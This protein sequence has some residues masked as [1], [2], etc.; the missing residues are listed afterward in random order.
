[1]QWVNVARICYSIELLI[2]F[3]SGESGCTYVLVPRL[4][5]LLEL[6]TPTR[7]SKAVFILVRSDSAHASA[8]LQGLLLGEPELWVSLESFHTK[9]ESST[10]CSP[11]NIGSS[12]WCGSISGFAPLCNFHCFHGAVPTSGW[13]SSG[14]HA[15]R[16]K[17]CAKNNVTPLQ[18]R[19]QGDVREWELF[20]FNPGVKWW[21]QI[22]L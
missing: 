2:A 18:L 11:G 7:C 1:M 19:S 9:A 4:S 16:R 12:V 21:V 5:Q 17:N 13:V 8:L 3:R 15:P 10:S 22:W 20:L 6:R 14:F